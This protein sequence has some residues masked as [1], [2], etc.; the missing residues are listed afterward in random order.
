MNGLKFAQPWWLAAIPAAMVLSLILFRWADV[1]RRK[2]L[3]AFASER[4]LETLT[5]SV[6][7]RRRFI[8]KILWVASVVLVF[9]SLAR[10][11]WGF[12]W[13]EVKRK[14]I[15]IL[16]AVDT[17][18]S[19]LAEDVKPNRLTRAKLAV[20]DLVEKLDG[21]RIGLIAFA[22]TA[23]LQCPLTLDYD[24]FGQA[25]DA[26][27]VNTIPRG[28]TNIASALEEAQKTFQLGNSNHKILILLTDGEDLEANGIEAAKQV[29]KQDLRVFTVG[30]GSVAGELIPMPME[31]GGIEFLRDASGQPVKSHLDENT[32]RQIAEA[33]GGFYVPLGQ[34]NEGLKTVYE[35]GLAPIPKQELFSRMNKVYKER[36]Q[37]PLG[38]ALLCLIVE[39]L[40][41]DRRKAGT[42]M[43]WKRGIRFPWKRKGIAI[44]VLCLAA[45]ISAEASPWKGERAYKQQDYDHA[46][47]QYK[48]AA[49]THPGKAE[50]Q[51]NAGAAAFKAK[52]YPE[53]LRA[54]E[55]ALKTD[56]TDLQ[57]QAFYNL[58][59]TQYR[60][61]QETEK[62]DRSQTIQQWQSAL[63]SY[64]RAMTLK[65]DDAD[66][67]YND[68][69][70]KKKLEKLQQLPPP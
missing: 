38:L 10:P 32:L 29:A 58:G 23:F 56:K 45:T 39:F 46:F 36:F 26:L 49:E 20:S 59:N 44:L 17:S 48:Q 66:A 28:G 43:D 51:F 7:T 11:Q 63:Q 13:E 6:S 16:I 12:R 2:A 60:L 69:F 57:Q 5:S 55:Q 24:A 4:L 70:V 21:D 47:E 27:D 18:K 65:S 19:M 53:A 33:T 15:D 37:W 34:Q 14:G 9:V 8:K 22:G 64:E 50:F 67:K 62:T 25:L 3:H 30:V 31:G 52:K 35:Q 54:F 61:G 68:E 40:I 1:K 41:S 42:W